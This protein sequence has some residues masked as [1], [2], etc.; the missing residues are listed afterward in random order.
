MTDLTLASLLILVLLPLML[1]VMLLLR[2]TAEGEVFYRQRR[3]GHRCQDFMIWKFA[4][5]LKDSPK[6]GTGSLTLR[7]DWRVTPVGRYLRI[8]KVNELPQLINVLTGEMSLVGPRPQVERDFL[9]YP[10]AIRERIYDVKPGITGIGSLVFRDEEALITAAN[11]DPHEFYRTH[12]APYKGELELW[13]QQRASVKTDL[14]I[15]L[16]TGWQVLS[17][18]SELVFSVFKDLPQR[19]PALQALTS[20]VSQA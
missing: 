12:I 16:L 5:M 18:G 7:N 11:M 10:E 15:L 2:L 9:A 17:P 1:P 3:K 20:I 4:T 14:L 19:P 8:T 6:L 13:Y